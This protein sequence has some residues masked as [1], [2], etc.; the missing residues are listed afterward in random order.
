MVVIEKRRDLGIWQAMGVSRSH[1]RHIF[2]IEGLTIGGIGILVGT[3][4]GLILCF[5]QDRF[6]LVPLM[7]GDSFIIDAYPVFVQYSDVL[8]IAL[9]VL[10]LCILVAVYPAWR[11][12]QTEPVE[13][14]RCRVYHPATPGTEA[15]SGF[16]N[17]SGVQGVVRSR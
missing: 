4:I 7:G 9:G 8:V 5:L 3:A 14:I 1:I 15:F 11:A 17:S 16:F 10:V 12:S 2:L 13:A 6:K